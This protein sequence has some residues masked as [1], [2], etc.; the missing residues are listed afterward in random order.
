M[1]PLATIADIAYEAESVAQ[2]V[3]RKPPSKLTL[4]PPTDEASTDEVQDAGRK[5]VRSELPI[6]EQKSLEKLIYVIA[7]DK[8]AYEYIGVDGSS[9]KLEAYNLLVGAYAVA[10]SILDGVYVVAT[11]PDTG[12]YPVVGANNTPVASLAPELPGTGLRYTVTRPLVDPAKLADAIGCNSKKST[13]CGAL[14]SL[15][16]GNGY[17]VSTMLDENRT[18]VE[19]NALSYISSSPVLATR[20]TRVMVDGPVYMTPGLLVRFYNMAQ[21]R[22][23]GPAI[24][25][26]AVYTLSYLLNALKRIRIV[27]SLSRRSVLVMGVV[28]RINRSRVLVN[29]LTSLNPDS[30]L[31]PTDPQLV[32]ALLSERG[33]Y[34]V[35]QPYAYGIGIAIGPVISIISAKSL[36]E[37]LLNALGLGG[38]HPIPFYNKKVTRSGETLAGIDRE[39]RGTPYVVKRS[40]YLVVK[41]GL[42]GHRIIR[43]EFPQLHTE[44]PVRLDQKGE[45]H[46][47][48]LEDNE[49]IIR[50]VVDNDLVV[51]REIAWLMTSPG[52]LEAPAPIVLADRVARTVSK[53]VALTW[54]SRL[55]D[56]VTFT[57][58][59]LLQLTAM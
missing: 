40:Y 2:A 39:A 19:N 53:T 34:P 22:G 57:Y 11:Y 3:K 6:R 28:K 35:M 36:W 18:L 47:E 21:F 45:I 1:S 37:A 54:F 31:P 20:Y 58:D 14:Q 38:Q 9:R 16:Y 46:V 10:T 30:Q 4:P 27:A 52:A 43:V 5:V 8:P 33:F 26:E 56:V 42:G 55:R 32:E 51:L 13:G 25:V 12:V 50:T 23:S 24:L 15:G 17:N 7:P 44:H 41:T 59:T 48:T 49:D 29:A